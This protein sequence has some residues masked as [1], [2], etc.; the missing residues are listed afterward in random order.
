VTTIEHQILVKGRDLDAYKFDAI[1]SLEKD[2][3]RK[4]VKLLDYD[5]I[6]G[7]ATIKPLN[8]VGVIAFDDDDYLEILPKIT[9]LE[10][11]ESIKRTKEVFLKMLLSALDMDPVETEAAKID[12]WQ[13]SL[14]EFFVKM[15]LR[16][17]NLIVSMGIRSGYSD[18][19]GNETFVK[20]RILFSEDITHNLAHR[21]RTYQTFQIFD[22]NRAENRLIKATLR[23]L[24]TVSNEYDNRKEI[25][26]LTPYFE[27]CSDIADVYSE[28]RNCKIDRNMK[29]YVKAIRWCE[30]FLLNRTLSTFSGSNIAYTFLFPMEKVFESY[31]AKTLE[32][33]LQDCDVSIQNSEKTLF[34]TGLVRKVRPDRVVKRNDSVVILDT[35]WK[36][37]ESDIDVSIDDLRQMK[38]YSADFEGTAMLLYPK[39][40][41]DEE[42]E[43]RRGDIVVKTKYLDLL[44]DFDG[45]WKH[46]IP[47]CKSTLHAHP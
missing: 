1:S 28:L 25:R 37:I 36:V 32:T 6:D 17:V 27:E 39:V 11:P 30:I 16:E 23:Y 42:I 38:E 31:V 14:F 5:Y 40:G 26:R 35:K 15:F 45:W 21:E 43:S 19:E 22:S 13:G 24:R 7:E 47:W 9:D 4:G 18:T 3:S 34:D 29:H 20:G 46:V 2:M 12:E 10:D 44:N 33:R 8:Y 41:F